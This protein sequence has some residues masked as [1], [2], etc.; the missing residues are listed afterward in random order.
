MSDSIP[1]DEDTA[2][3]ALMAG[4]KGSKT[5]PVSKML[6][7]KAV[8]YKVKNLHSYE[9][10]AK[11]YNVSSTL[12]AQFDKLNNLHEQVQQLIEDG[13]LGLDQGYRISL[14]PKERQVSVARIS[15]NL[16]S[17]DTRNLIEILK[18][19][20]KISAEEAKERLSRAQ[21]VIEK[22]H[23]LP[24]VLSNDFFADL[25]K[26]ASSQKMNPE[27]FVISLIKN[28]IKRRQASS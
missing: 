19:N 3:A 18:N 10:V 20:P 17:H 13:S 26:L 27:E 24:L 4:F 12:I 21:T 23:I 5:K 2:D 22:M 14:L 1:M 9:E 6:M 8:R 11:A 7:A 25:K 28:E 16:N 15:R